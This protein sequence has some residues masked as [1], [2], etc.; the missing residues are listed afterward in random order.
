MAV[1]NCVFTGRLTR[2]PEL[3]VTQSDKEVCNFSIACETG[4]GKGKKVTY[5]PF[6]AW[7]GR[8]KFVSAL[9]K[10][11]MVVIV[12]KYDENTYKNQE[13]ENR[14]RYDF[15]V[16]HIESLEPKSVTDG[17]SADVEPPSYSEQAEQRGQAESVAGATEP[18]TYQDTGEEE[19][20]F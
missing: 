14:K 10:G 4:W 3:K 20:P 8:A 6:V 1:N 5:P 9:P 11:T 13:G 18:T 16:E 12:A 7:G 2:A 17:Y 15:I 19:L